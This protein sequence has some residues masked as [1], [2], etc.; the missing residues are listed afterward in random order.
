[1]KKLLAAV[2]Y[3]CLM[4][5]V[6]LFAQNAGWPPPAGAQAALGVYNSVAPTITNKQANFLQT[7]VNGNLKV[8]GGGGSGTVSVDVTLSNAFA[9]VAPATA[10]ATNSDLI[11]C[12][13]NTAGY[14]P[15][16]T[17]QMAVGCDQNGRLLTVDGSAVQVASTPTIQAAA[18]AINNCIG[19]FNAVTVT[20]YN[21][22]SAFLTHI[23]A[24]SVGGTAYQLMGYV[25]DS[26][27]TT[28]VCTDKGTFSISTADIDKIIATVNATT[29]ATTGGSVSTPTAVTIDYT[30]PKPFAAGGS[31]ASG[32]STFWYGFALAA[33]A[34]P[35]SVSDLHLRFGI[36]RE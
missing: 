21:G 1:M 3:F 11:G 8:V 4:L 19:G 24:L 36:A 10:T 6:P 16:N 13:Y 2:V 35:L 14:A 22:Q 20:T 32:V 23:R 18:Y 29:L 34:T 33:A 9:P 26:Q 15:T 12:Q 28:S 30:P 17:Q 5:S 27:P 7:D 25:F 31:A